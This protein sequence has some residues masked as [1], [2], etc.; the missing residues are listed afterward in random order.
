[1]TTDEHELQARR[2]LAYHAKTGNSWREDFERWADTKDFSK[3]DVME[4][5]RMAWALALLQE[6]VSTDPMDWFGAA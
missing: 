1:M 3:R 5:R 4:I 6:Y 2:F